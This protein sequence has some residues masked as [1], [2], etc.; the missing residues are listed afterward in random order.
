MDKETVAISVDDFVKVQLEITRSTLDAY[1][2]KAKEFQGGKYT[3]KQL[4]ENMLRNWVEGN[5]AK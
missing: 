1:K 4:M 5:V 2:A 3:A